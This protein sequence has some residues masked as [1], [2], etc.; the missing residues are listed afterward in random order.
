LDRQV[1]LVIFFIVNVSPRLL[2]PTRA[3]IVF[4]LFIPVPLLARLLDYVVIVHNHNLFL[5]G[6][7]TFYYLEVWF[8]RSFLGRRK[9][10]WW[11]RSRFR[12]R[13]RGRCGLGRTKWRPDRK[14]SLT[15]RALDVS[16]RTIRDPEGRGAFGAGEKGHRGSSS[17]A[18][19]IEHEKIVKPD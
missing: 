10:R 19:M 5:R 18:R 4:I 17:K 16:R 9:R 8:P 15:F 1:V 7:L 13:G 14:E 2:F 12:R 3:V 11:R 6:E